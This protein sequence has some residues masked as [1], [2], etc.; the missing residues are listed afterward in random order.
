MVLFKEQRLIDTNAEGRI[1]IKDSEG[2]A[3]Y[4]N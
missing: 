1:A 3:R 2:L 4:C